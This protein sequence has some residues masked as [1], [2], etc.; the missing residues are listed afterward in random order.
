MKPATVLS[1]LLFAILTGCATPPPAGDLIL[2]AE[3]IRLKR[4]P[5][6][7]SDIPCGEYIYTHTAVT[8]SK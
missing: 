7:E 8:Y 4:K 2:T 3:D 6:V 1:C 5:Y